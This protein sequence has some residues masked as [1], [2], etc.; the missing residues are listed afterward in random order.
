MINNSKNFIELKN[1]HLT[2]HIGISPRLNGQYSD[3]DW[4][5]L[6]LYNNGQAKIVIQHI[7]DNSNGK[8]VEWAKMRLDFLK[9]REKLYLEALNGS[10]R[11]FGYWKLK[12]IY[13]FFFQHYWNS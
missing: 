1:E 8:D 13:K 2:F 10:N 7:I 6:N 9:N 5:K 11:H 3:S 4:V 12:K